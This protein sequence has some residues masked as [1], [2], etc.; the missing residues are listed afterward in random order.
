M[1]DKMLEEFKFSREKERDMM[2]SVVMKNLIGGMRVQRVDESGEDEEEEML[3]RAIEE[4]K[5]D[6]GIDENTQPDT[7]NMTYE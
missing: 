2:M 3:R 7:D 5:R 6:A 4:S 1:E